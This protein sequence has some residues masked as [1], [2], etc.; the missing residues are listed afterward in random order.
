MEQLE[1]NEQLS[2]KTNH[3]ENNTINSREPLSKKV[4]VKEN[5]ESTLKPE[6]VKENTNIAGNIS[7][8]IVKETN[9]EKKEQ[10]YEP[11]FHFIKKDKI[12]KF[13]QHSSPNLKLKSELKKTNIKENTEKILSNKSNKEPERLQI[14]RQEKEKL[15]M[16]VEEKPSEYQNASKDISTNKNKETSEEEIE[17][18]LWDGEI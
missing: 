18:D 10:V 17:E 5:N 15:Q 9:K 1:F 4:E 6:E 8:L 13:L 3:A 11:H 12:E 16:Q 7:N 14:Q 2:N